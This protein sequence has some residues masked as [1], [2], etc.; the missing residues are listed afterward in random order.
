[1]SFG[2][3]SKAVGV[4]VNKERVRMKGEDKME[5]QNESAFEKCKP[6]LGKADYLLLSFL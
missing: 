1:M 5:R 2:K 6:F 4:V 3:M